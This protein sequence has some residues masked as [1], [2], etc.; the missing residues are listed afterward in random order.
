[1]KPLLIALDFDGTLTRIRKRPQGAVLSPSM[2]CLLKKI[3]RRY[4]LAIW[5]GRGLPQLKKKIKVGGLFYAGNHGLEITGPGFTFT[6]PAARRNR[7]LINQ[8]YAQLSVGLKKIPSVIEDKR[9]SISVH[10][11]ITPAHQLA[12][13]KK[14]FYN[15]TGP[16]A[17][18][19]Q[20]V[21]KGGKKVLEVL[22]PLKWH[23]GHA[24]KL[25]QQH[26]GN[27]PILYL[28]DDLTD[29]DVFRVLGKKD[30]GILVGRPRRKTFAKERLSGIPAVRKL[31]KSLVK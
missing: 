17:R 11:R 6:H 21:V 20:I 19:R 31:L 27:I 22:P 29:E 25:L 3:K 8:L 14:I 12:T 30:R 28:G 24:L 26:L 4:P 10:Y 9:Y 23:K 1:M 13:L 2:R 15:I 18:R 16:L 5:S 7:K